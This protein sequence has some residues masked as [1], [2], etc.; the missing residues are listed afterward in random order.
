MGV[1]RYG[2][3][4]Q[5]FQFQ[6]AGQHDATRGRMC[7]RSSDDVQ[8][9]LQKNFHSLKYYGPITNKFRITTVWTL[10]RTF[11]HF[12][13]WTVSKLQFYERDYVILIIQKTK[14]SDGLTKNFEKF[15]NFK[16]L[17]KTWKFLRHLVSIQKY[18]SSFENTNIWHNLIWALWKPIIVQITS[19]CIYIFMENETLIPANSFALK[20]T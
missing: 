7:P 19:N 12:V 3:R 2:I 15:W 4:E 13:R 20:M 8:R 11:W 10:K 16:H 9:H 18:S 6:N 14:N 17:L 5:I 1:W